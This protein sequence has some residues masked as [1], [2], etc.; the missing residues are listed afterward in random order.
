MTAA[1]S[2]P[3]ATHKGT[4][5]LPHADTPRAISRLWMMAISSL[6][7]LIYYYDYDHDYGY[8]YYYYDYY[9][10]YVGYYY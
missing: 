10:Y 8:Y 7:I 5:A 1:P 9:Y 3:L 6:L 4:V 2:G